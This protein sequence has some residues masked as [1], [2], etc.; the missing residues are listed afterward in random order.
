VKQLPLHQQCVKYFES[1]QA[2]DESLRFVEYDASDV[3][4]SATLN[5]GDSPLLKVAKSE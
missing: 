3:A 4:V 1:L 2:V 5:Q